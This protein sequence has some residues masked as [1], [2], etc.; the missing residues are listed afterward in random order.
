ML[1]GLLPNGICAFSEVRDRL[2]DCA[3]KKRL[4][5]GAQSVWMFLFPYLLE[6]KAYEGRNISR[7]AVVR[8]Y[9]EIVSELLGAFCEDLRRRY[10]EEKFEPFCDDSPI[11]EVCCAARAG[12]GVIGENGLLIN[13]VYGSYVFIGEVVT[14]KYFHPAPGTAGPCLRCGK[15]REACPTGALGRKG[16]DR[17]RCLSDISQRKALTA[18]QEKILVRSGC[19]WG[20]DV[21]QE[22]CP[23]NRSAKVTALTAFREGA[24]AHLSSP[25]SLA[26]RAYAWRGERV[27]TRN[28]RLLLG[29]LEIKGESE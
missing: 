28:L 5:E 24:L 25:V 20:C 19:A 15:C 2:L 17:A 21:C 9:H 14:T 16:F 13:P 29:G 10:P 18:E 8:D 4:P 23:M 12:L 1:D 11:S 26:G 6:E 22:V 3:A 7:Y 27:I